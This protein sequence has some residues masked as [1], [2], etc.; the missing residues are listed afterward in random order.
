MSAP[1]NFGF[2]GAGQIAHWAA[3]AL[4][5]HADAR[6]VAAQDLNAGRVADLCKAKSIPKAYA[7]AC[8]LLADPEINAVYIAVPNKFHAPLAI[9][10]LEAGKHVLLEKPFAMSHAEASEVAAA[11]KKAGKVMTLGMN[12]RF[13]PEVQKARHFVE[14][15]K[16]GEVYHAKAYWFRRSGIPRLGTWFGNRELAG[17]GCLYDIG[18]HMLDACLHIINNFE[19]VS[20][21]GAT[22]GK[23]GHRGLGEGGWGISDRAGLPFDVE[24]FASGFIRFAN[25][26]TVTL[27][28]TWACHQSAGNKHSI[29]LFGTEAGLDVFKGEL[30]SAAPQGSAG[31]YQ[32]IQQID[33]PLAYPHADRFHNFVNHLLGKEALVVTIEQALT[34]QRILDGIAESAATGREARL[35]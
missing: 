30:Y 27:D 4:K 29:E 19:P 26:A 20:V 35:A 6:L 11:A 2:I 9:Q 33:A 18:V 21:V 22:Y 1:V 17:G 8:E 15:G 12:F 13:T 31:G 32:V 7:D 14:C 10:A 24:D 23:F 34:I 3:D 16:L 5:S 25:G 28:T